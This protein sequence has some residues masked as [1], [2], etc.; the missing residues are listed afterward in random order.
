MKICY[1]KQLGKI[2]KLDNMPYCQFCFNPAKAIHRI[3][4]IVYSVCDQC[5]SM[6]ADQ[7]LKQQKKIAWTLKISNP[8]K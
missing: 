6:F 4:K 8:Y 3:D 2:D 7:T 1:C 5:H